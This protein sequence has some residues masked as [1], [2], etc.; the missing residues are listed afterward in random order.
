HGDAVIAGRLRC[1]LARLREN[2]QGIKIV[3]ETMDQ[4]RRGVLAGATAASALAGAGSRAYARWEP[5]ES[6]PDPAFEL[7]D[8][9]FAKYRVFNAAVERLAGGLRWSE[10]PA[11]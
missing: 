10:G 11:W 9:G 8:P 2:V 3:E 1:L 6:Y 4:T 7:L 5:A